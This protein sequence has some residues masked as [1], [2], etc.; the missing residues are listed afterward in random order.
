LRTI[1][2]LELIDHLDQGAILYYRGGVH[3]WMTL[4]F[5]V[6]PGGHGVAS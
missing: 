6:R 2:E 4:G 5:Q 3:D 1:G